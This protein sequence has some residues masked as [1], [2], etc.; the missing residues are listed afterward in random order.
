[1]CARLQHPYSNEFQ[2]GSSQECV[3]SLRRWKAKLLLEC[4]SNLLRWSERS[5]PISEASKS[6]YA[7]RLSSLGSALLRPS[8]CLSWAE[9]DGNLVVICS[10][11]RHEMK[12]WPTPSGG[13]TG[14]VRGS[15]KWLGFILW[16]PWSSER[17]AQSVLISL[18]T[19]TFSDSD[20]AEMWAW[21][22]WMH[23]VHYSLLQ[24]EESEQVEVFSY[25]SIHV[26][27]QIQS[28]T[29]RSCIVDHNFIS[30]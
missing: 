25:V 7:H 15:L 22:E 2:F 16:E 23:C 9:A 19:L 30:K 6:K 4:N 21:M 1:M 11:I 10:G 28:I 26:S 8:C 13:V 18:A 20:Q 27:N 29:K 12:L 14:R 3:C 24:Y 17:S 5:D